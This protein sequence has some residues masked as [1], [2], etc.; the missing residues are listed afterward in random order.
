MCKYKNKLISIVDDYFEKANASKYILR[1]KTHG[2]LVL[3]KN[4]CKYVEHSLLY[5][6]LKLW[7]E[8]NIEIKN[9]SSLNT[10]KKRLKYYLVQNFH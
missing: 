3:P 2:T 7:N 10:F 4:S 5:R 6:G 8:L 1:S 9:I